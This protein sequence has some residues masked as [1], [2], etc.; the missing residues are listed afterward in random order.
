[1]YISP[2]DNMLHVLIG[3]FT[4]PL[5]TRAEDVARAIVAAV[6][7][8]DG[9]KPV[10]A[11]FLSAEG[12]PEELPSADFNIPSYAFPE[13]AAIALARAAR[14]REWRERPETVAAEFEDLQKD[15]AAAVVAAALGRGGGWLTAEETA[16]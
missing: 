11:V 7:T 9:S 2:A 4:P 5:V 10:M 12:A 14:Y 16:K 13:T 1:M 6:K 3:I 15:E 8:F